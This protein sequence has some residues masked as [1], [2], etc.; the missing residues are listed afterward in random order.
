MIEPVPRVVARHRLLVQQPFGVVHVEAQE[1]DQF[2]CRVDLG[3]VRRLAL[4]QQGGCVD[5]LAPGTGQQ[6][7][8][9]EEHGSPILEPHR[10]PVTLSLHSSRH[11]LAEQRGIGAM[12]VG[13]AMLVALGGKHPLGR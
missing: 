9:T 4:P 6:V 11:R 13:H 10:G 2:A 5:A 12:E 3:L 7:G 1:V 8:G